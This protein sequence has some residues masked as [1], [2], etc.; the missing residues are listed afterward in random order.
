MY[1][2]IIYICLHV[3]DCGSQTSFE[4]GSNDPKNSRPC[5]HSRM[6]RSIDFMAFSVTGYGHK[7]GGSFDRNN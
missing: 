2:Y 5:K 4:S 7:I 1:I 6:L 3:N